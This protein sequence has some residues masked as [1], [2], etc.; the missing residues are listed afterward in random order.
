MKT[1][2]LSLLILFMGTPAL[3]YADDSD[4]LT[5]NQ[6]SIGYGPVRENDGATYR[7]IRLDDRL[8]THF[9]GNIGGIIG[10]DAPQ[11]GLHD[12]NSR[13]DYRTFWIGGSFIEVEKYLFGSVGIVRLT[14]Q[15]SHLTSPYQ[16]LI[17]FGVHYEA[18]S[19]SYVHLSNGHTGGKNYGEDMLVL[20]YGF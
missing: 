20:G 16:F 18:A 1:F 5:V 11:K 7:T 17:T 15:T 19:L 9:I 6:L 10:G 2:I 14:K 13:F 12:A 4:T 3:T 8:S